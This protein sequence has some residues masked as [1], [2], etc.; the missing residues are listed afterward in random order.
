MANTIDVF[1]KG[2]AHTPQKFWEYAL[3]TETKHSR[4]YNE[5]GFK[6][7]EKHTKEYMSLNDKDKKKV[8]FV[9][10]D[11]IKQKY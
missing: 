6:Y 10:I 4:V 1:L 7:S 11:G 3:R 5:L 8:R 2:D 9:F